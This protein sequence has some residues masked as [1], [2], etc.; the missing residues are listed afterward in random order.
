MDWNCRCCDEDLVLTL[1]NECLPSNLKEG[2]TNCIN[3][4]ELL[5]DKD[6]EEYCVIC[7]LGYTPDETGVCVKTPEK[8]L[9]KGCLLI[10]DDRCYVCDTGYE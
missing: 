2:M 3:F 1:N 7:K 10:V 4:V 9:Q 5:P 6:N 8:D